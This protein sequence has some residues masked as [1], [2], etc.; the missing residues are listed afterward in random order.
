MLAKK[1]GFL[2]TFRC[3]GAKME[4]PAKRLI[5]GDRK[6]LCVFFIVVILLGLLFSMCHVA[7]NS[8]PVAV[9]DVN[10]TRATETK[11]LVV[12]SLA[13]RP[14]EPLPGKS[15]SRASITT[16]QQQPAETPKP[17]KSETAKAEPAKPVKTEKAEREGATKL[18]PVSGS[19]PSGTY[20]QLAA[21]PK[22]EVDIMVDVLRQKKFAV[23]TAEIPGKLGLFRVLVGPLAETEINKTKTDLQSAGFQGDKSFTRSF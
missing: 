16:A 5:I 11:P 15:A 9:T 10:P 8:A 13:S 19:A 21:G 12:E 7:R 14:V 3:R 2:Y 22:A 23:I 1:K 17:P 18:S 6:L 4:I 20:L